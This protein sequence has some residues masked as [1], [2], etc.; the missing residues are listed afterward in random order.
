MYKKPSWVRIYITIWI[1][2]VPSVALI[3]GVG[4]W[5]EQAHFPLWLS[6]LA[7]IVTIHIACGWVWLV[8]H[9]ID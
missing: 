9:L 5:Q 4:N 1:S 2:V 6:I 7:M 3:Y 8:V